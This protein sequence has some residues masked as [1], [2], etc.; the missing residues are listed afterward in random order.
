MKIGKVVTIRLLLK[1]VYFITTIVLIV[2]L[3]ILLYNVGTMKVFMQ[4]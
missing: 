3:R 4:G 2:H 1:C